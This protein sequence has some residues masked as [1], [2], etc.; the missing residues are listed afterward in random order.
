MEA[1]VRT[2]I[3]L[4]RQN[5]NFL[6]IRTRAR[7]RVFYLGTPHM[8]LWGP[9]VWPKNHVFG[10]SGFELI[11]TKASGGSLDASLKAGCA[12]PTLSFREL[13][14]HK[15]QRFKVEAIILAPKLSLAVFC[16]AHAMGPSRPAAA[17]SELQDASRGT[18]KHAGQ[19]T[20]APC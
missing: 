12:G 6:T 4:F 1:V 18:Y 19:G 9:K 15:Q 20:E 14:E 17:P 3:E 7:K 13:D 10:L 8:Y 11:A 5:S 16:T 2:Q